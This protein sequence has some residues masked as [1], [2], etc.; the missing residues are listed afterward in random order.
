MDPERWA[1]IDRLLDQALVRPSATHA[2]FLA[3]ACE[4]DDELLGEVESLLDAHSHPE[5]FLGTPA[6][7]LAARLTGERQVSL[8][9]KRLGTY[10]VISVLGMG[11]MGEV[12]LARDER[13]N[14][15]LALKFL[16][17]QLTRDT[18]SLMR[19][20]REARAASALNHPN[21]IIIYDIGEM[22]GTYFIA[23]EYVEGKTLRQLIERG[24]L[25]LRDTIAI[26]SQV[27]D[28]WLRWFRQHVCRARFRS[29]TN[30]DLSLVG[31]A[32]RRRTGRKVLRPP[33]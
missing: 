31:P 5:S 4:N 30:D 25:R 27:A 13:L 26:C 22:A 6:L 28:R 33:D 7:D 3:T 24:P 23:A 8:V 15:K 19:F 10:E 9:G 14:R 2:A 11:G 18:N 20:E 29:E 1:K 16:P 17:H 32:R 21:I 12:Y